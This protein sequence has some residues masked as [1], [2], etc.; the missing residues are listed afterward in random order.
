MAVNIPGLVAVIVFYI[1]ILVIGIWASKR[2][3]KEEKKCSGE[4]SEVTIVGGRNLNAWVG[5]FTLTATWVGGGYILGTAEVVYT[6]TQ[7]LFWALGPLGYAASLFLGGIYFVKPMRD[8]KY[9]TMI[10]PF[11]EK[12]GNVLS[13]LLVVTSVFSDVFW[14]ACILSALGGTIEV[15]LDISSYHSILV[16]AAVAI[17]YTLLGGLYSV[18]YTDVIQ[19]F[20]IAISLWI[21]VPFLMMS[22]A[23]TNILVTASEELYQKPWIT[24]VD[25]EHL[26]NWLDEL[27]IITLGGVCYQSFYQRVLATSS[28]RQGQIMCHLSGVFCFIL[29]IPSVLIGAIAAST[30]WNQTSYGFPTPFDNGDARKILPISLQHLCPKFISVIGIGAVASAVMSSVDSSLL[31][32]ASMFAHNIYK[33]LIRKKAS[34]KEVLWAIRIGVLFFGA[35]GTCLALMAQSV[36][37]L[38]ILSA[39]MV[40]SLIFSQLVCVLFVPSSNGYGALAGF[41]VELIMRVAGGE[42]FLRIPPLIHYP[43]G[44]FIDG[45]YIQRFPFKTLTV[46]IS[47]VT[48]VAVSHLSY[49]LFNRGLLSE[50]CD[51]YSVKEKIKKDVAILQNKNNFITY[52]T[53]QDT[54][55]CRPLLSSA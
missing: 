29:G 40:F 31:S 45:V 5:V 55:F 35:V 49:F 12:Y 3:K 6:P 25:L 41:F 26:G 11:Q 47:L 9:L 52:N 50:C 7:G 54:C 36:Y 38:W 20:F 28:V 43:G 39:E 13:S 19:L 18:V 21:C 42:P 4:R 8:K 27:F 34:G 22:P 24:E 16:S 15:I 32:S 53:S 33:K 51:I 37:E 17:F 30:D 46:G 14:T 48:I 1:I 44:T 2:S 23:V 10:D